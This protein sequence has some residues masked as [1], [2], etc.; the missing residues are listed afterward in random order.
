MNRTRSIALFLLAMVSIGGFVLDQT[1]RLQPLED[2]ALR[3][4]IPLQRAI[5]HL[6]TQGSGLLQAVRE[7]GSLE[8]RN[9][10]LE[11]LVDRLMSENVRLRE[12]EIENVTL[13]QQLDFKQAN[14]SY[15]LL[16]AEVIGQDP[17]G[18]LHYLIIDRGTEDGVAEGMPVATAA[19]LVGRISEVYSHSAKV[20]LI[21]DASSSVNALIQSSRATGV[22]QGGMGHGLVMR[23]IQQG[24]RVDVGDMVLTSGLGGN[25]P[26]RLVIGQVTAVK[27]QDIEMFQEVEV[28]PAVDFSR[29][30]MLIVIKGFTPTD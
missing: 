11:E 1:H 23:Y 30:E 4:I 26:K 6:I 3:P 18:F 21:T 15:K 5:G 14:P 12:A 7:W 19:G 10:E 20:L 24:E 13:R 16:A 2:V 17:S 27:Q 8:A 22:V 9:R 28:R 25:F 29:L